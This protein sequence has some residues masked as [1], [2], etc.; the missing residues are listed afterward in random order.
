MFILVFTLPLCVMRKASKVADCGVWKYEEE[1]GFI[2]RNGKFESGHLAEKR[3]RLRRGE[4]D[5]RVTFFL[6]D[7]SRILTTGEL[8]NS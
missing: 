4:K 2:H 6:L 1:E 7:A 8:G 3:S 5:F